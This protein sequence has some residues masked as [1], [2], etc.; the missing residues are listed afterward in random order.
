MQQRLCQESFDAIG[1][2]MQCSLRQYIQS[3]LKRL[4]S[5][6]KD[7]SQFLKFWKQGVY[8]KKEARKTVKRL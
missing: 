5:Q 6:V 4:Q 7:I 2:E 1:D 3:D 8:P